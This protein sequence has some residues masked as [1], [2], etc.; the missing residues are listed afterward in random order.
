[1]SHL[2]TRV[3]LT[4]SPV[5]LQPVP[6]YGTHTSHGHSVDVPMTE[7]HTHKDCMFE[8]GGDSGERHAHT[9]YYNICQV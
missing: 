5:S 3:L 9:V 8:E 2:W 6:S 7:I 1:M 4:F